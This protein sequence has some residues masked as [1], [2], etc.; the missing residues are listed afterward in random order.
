MPSFHCLPYSVIN[1]A[2]FSNIQT[3]LGLFICT[4]VQPRLQTLTPRWWRPRCRRRGRSGWR[5]AGW[6]WGTAAAGRGWWRRARTAGTAAPSG[7]GRGWRLAGRRL[8]HSALRTATSATV[9]GG[10][11]SKHNKSL[12]GCWQLLFRSTTAWTQPLLIIIGWGICGYRHSHDVTQQS[13]D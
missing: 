9:S 12:Q 6:R 5:P 4:T 3:N 8:A 7:R 1:S 13:E 11:N 10:R 2:A